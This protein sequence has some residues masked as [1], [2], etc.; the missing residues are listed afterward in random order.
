MK[1]EDISKYCELMAEVKR[2]TLVIDAF[3]SGSAQAVFKASTI[4]CVYLQFRKILELIALGSLVANREVFSK[5]YL[6]FSK[7]WNAELLLKDVGRL[8]PNFYPKPIIQGKSADPN[9]K[10]EWKDR[11]ND[12]LTQRDLVKLYKKTGAILHADNPYGSKIDY[13]YYEREIE[14]WRLKII[15]L[16]NA[17]LIHLVGSPNI[18]LM[19]MG[20]SGTSPTYTVFSPY[21]PHSG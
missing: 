5:V 11:H 17:H 14:G 8:N 16:L 1:P 19:Q 15:N 10:S 20:A 12:W 21:D 6:N 3:G 18:Y 9:I 4:E 13:A 2:R 7:Y